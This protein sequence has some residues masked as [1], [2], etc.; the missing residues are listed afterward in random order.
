MLNNR[1][2]A[3]F[4]AV[5]FLMLSTLSIAA[6]PLP[7]SAYYD[8]RFKGLKARAEISLTQI[9]DT[10]FIASSLIRLRLLGAT[11]STIRENSQ[12]DWL[13]NAP[14]PQHYEYNQSGIGGR[15]RSITFDWENNLATAIVKDE[16][17]ELQLEDITLD[18][19]SMYTLIRQEL[20][21]GNDEI[22]FAV[23][24]RN[25]VKEYHY[26]VIREEYLAIESGIFSA[27]KVE[28]VRENSERLTQ[29]WFAKDND[30]LLLKLYQRD[31]D[32]D[33]FEITLTDAQIN[34][35]AIRPQA[36]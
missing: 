20:L 18:E 25:V 24:D 9:S 21:N 16:S 26:R 27:I 32:G 13:N 23:I 22:I 7:F 4:C 1:I 36:N 34:G 30:M 2:A 8:A 3:I 11:V 19:L 17:V 35:E 29:L 14:R 12:F 5:T 28:R 33:E 31:P 6:P 10:E 15:S